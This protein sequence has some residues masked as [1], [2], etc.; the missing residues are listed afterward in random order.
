MYCGRSLFVILSTWLVFQCW[1]WHMYNVRW[2]KLWNFI[3]YYCS[4]PYNNSRLISKLWR[5]SKFP[6]CCFTFK[7][8]RKLL[9]LNILS[10]LNWLKFIDRTT[11]NVLTAT[12]SFC[13]AREAFT[14]MS[15]VKLAILMTMSTVLLLHHHRF[16]QHQPFLQ[17]HV[18]ELKIFNLSPVNFHV[19]TIIN[20]STLFPICC[21]VLEACTSIKEF[22]PV[23]I[24]RM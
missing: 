17:W 4:S 5:S 15:N 22:R 12:R 9:S 1:I 24:Q 18:K 19:P 2:S 16:Q 21:H 8:H 20:A 11:I 14:L 3:T 23:I 6:L 7:L 10:S 13:H